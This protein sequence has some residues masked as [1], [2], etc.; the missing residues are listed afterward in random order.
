MKCKKKSDLKCVGSRSRAVY[1]VGLRPFACWD[2][3]FES[4]PGAWM[5]VCCECCV[6][7]DR[8]LCVGLITRPEEF[9]RVWC[10]VVCDL[11]TLWMRSP[12]PT[13]GCCGKRKKIKKAESFLCVP[14]RHVEGVEVHFHLLLTWRWLRQLNWKEISKYQLDRRVGGPKSQSGLFV[15]LLA[16]IA[17]AMYLVAIPLQLWK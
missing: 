3:G 15:L 13:G 7:S 2:C 17:H 5:S 12:R 9:Y 16:G 1:G 11:E 14:W 4:H 6:L 8:G 10:V